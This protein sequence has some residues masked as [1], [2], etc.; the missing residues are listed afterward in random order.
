MP[1][2]ASVRNDTEQNNR[3]SLLL[4]SFRGEFDSPGWNRF[5]LYPNYHIVGPDRYRWKG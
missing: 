4:Y 2:E 5:K 1:H 3:S